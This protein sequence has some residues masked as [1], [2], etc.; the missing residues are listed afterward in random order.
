MC[1]IKYVNTIFGSASVYESLRT[2]TKM[3][4]KLICCGLHGKLI[5]KQYCVHISSEL[6]EPNELQQVLH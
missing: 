3:T 2:T 6:N 4:I 5:K 1:T